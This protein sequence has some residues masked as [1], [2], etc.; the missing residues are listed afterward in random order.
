MSDPAT[1]CKIAAA[2]AKTIEVQEKIDQQYPNVE[3]S[4]IVFNT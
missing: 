4:I 2:I 3:Q 1:Y